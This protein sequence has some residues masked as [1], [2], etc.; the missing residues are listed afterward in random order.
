MEADAKTFAGFAAPLA[1]VYMTYA[2]ISADVVTGRKIEM[3]P[4]PQAQVS[5]APALPSASGE[6]RNPFV[7]AGHDGYAFENPGGKG[8]GDANEA[9][10]LDGTVLAGS[11]RFA[12]INGT[13]VMEGDFFRGLKLEKVEMSQVRLVG[14][15]QEVVLP[16]GI[17]KSDAILPVETAALDRSAERGDDRKT[18]PASRPESEAGSLLRGGSANAASK[19]GAK[20]RR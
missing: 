18:K 6:L 15:K 4:I 3:K 7:A 16:L 12:I 13:R 14:G 2:A 5:V 19:A 17:A 8:G 10:R 20:E 11:L 9:L 1:I